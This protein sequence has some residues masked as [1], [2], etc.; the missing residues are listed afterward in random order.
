MALARPRGAVPAR[1]PPAPPHHSAVPH[2]RRLPG[3]VRTAAGVRFL[4]VRLPRHRHVSDR[5]AAELPAIQLRL[6]RGRQDDRDSQWGPIGDTHPLAPHVPGHARSMGV[7]RGR[8]R[9]LDGLLGVRESRGGVHA[10]TGVPTAGRPLRGSP[11]ASG[12]ATGRQHAEPHPEEQHG[13]CHR[14]HRAVPPRAPRGRGE[15]VHGMRHPVPRDLVVQAARGHAQHRRRPLRGQ[16]LRREDPAVRE[17]LCP[18]P[19]RGAGVPLRRRGS[20]RDGVQ[21]HPGQRGDQRQ[22]ARVP[23]GSP[24]EASD[25]LPTHTLGFVQLPVRHGPQCRA[26]AGSISGDQ[27]RQ[28]SPAGA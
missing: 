2:R 13:R 19:R 1:P 11:S 15:A 14:V 6:P 8:V 27:R 28:C 18:G 4:R 5:H 20:G 22:A 10:Q 16:A 25:R 26:H 7:P 12:R 17:G 3:L 23:R 24:S 21:H 9:C